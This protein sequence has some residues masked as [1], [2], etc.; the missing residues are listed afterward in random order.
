MARLKLSDR[1]KKAIT[2]MPESEKDKILLR[3]VA[4]DEA[5]VK[6]LA[7]ELLEG[8]QEQESRR[9]S[10]YEGIE[11]YLEDYNRQGYYYSPGYLL[12]ELRN[13]SGRITDHVK[14]TKDKYGEVQLNLLMVVNSLDLFGDEINSVTPKRSKTLNNYIVKR[15]LKILTLLRRMHPDVVLDFE[16][17]LKRLGELISQ[18]KAM[19][20]VATENRLDVK[21]LKEGIVK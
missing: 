3:L 18:Q 12:M 20:V 6:K 13:I 1:L 16:D 7:F 5:L 21:G 2:A 19:M 11:Q 8:K 14:T 15:T 9:K 10:L 17:D 4:K